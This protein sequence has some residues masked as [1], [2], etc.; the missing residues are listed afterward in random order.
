MEW[1]PWLSRWSEEWVRSAEPGE[2]E[3]DVARERWLGFAPASEEAVAAAEARLGCVFPP[4]YRDFLLTTDGW[5]HAGQFVWK[6]RDTGNLGW[7]R[8]IEP[9]WA[10]WEDLTDDPGA[11]DDN[12]FTRGLLISLEADAGILFLDPGDVGETG[13]WAAYSLF[14]WRAE[15][16]ERFESFAALMEDLYAEFHQMRQP[17]GDTRDHWDAEVERAR[18]DALAGN[19]DAAG[20]VL[21]KAE[22]FGRVRATV[23]RSQLLLLLNRHYEAG[24]L[25]GRLLHPAFMPDGFLD[26]PLFTEEFLPWL[27]LQHDQTVRPGRASILEGAMIGDRPEM[28]N[29]L[30][31]RPTSPTFGNPEFD[32]LIRQAIDTHTD[33]ALWT[34]AVAALPRWRPRTADHIAPIALLAH[35]AFAATLT[36]AR[37]RA[38]LTAVRG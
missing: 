33:D 21:A 26:D 19:I 6:L 27:F 38:I 32:I 2:L 17:E 23:L 16:P 22:E 4:S 15:P 24:M 36:E 20:A 11:A 3:P 8:D 34:A 31:K 9:F 29:L 5:R 12:R 13:E 35:P 30:D 37:G 1:R 14:S 7:L 25:V 10:E 18:A 28:R